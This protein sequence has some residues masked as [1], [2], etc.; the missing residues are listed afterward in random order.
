MYKIVVT[1]NV[2]T[3][4]LE[5]WL[6]IDTATSSFGL[7]RFNKNIRMAVEEHMEREFEQIGADIFSQTKED[8]DRIFQHEKE[9]KGKIRTIPSHKEV[10]DSEA[11]QNALKSFRDQYPE[12]EYIFTKD[13]D[14]K[15]DEA[16]RWVIVKVWCRA[17]H[18]QYPFASFRLIFTKVDDVTQMLP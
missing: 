9:L 10:K 4:K 16:K 2:D 12:D 11:Y 8:V 13:W 18:L 15:I 5:E 14:G 7:D 17:G 3:E 6:G 1:I